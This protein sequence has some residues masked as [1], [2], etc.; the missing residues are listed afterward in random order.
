MFH[1]VFVS[2][3]T[4]TRSSNLPSPN[5]YF[6]QLSGGGE[7]NRGLN[8]LQKSSKLQSEDTLEA[9]LSLAEQSFVI[10]RRT[11]IRQHNGTKPDSVLLERV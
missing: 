5:L 10:F 2:Q 3:P 1:K 8:V 9:C 4:G 11:L 6:I 7:T